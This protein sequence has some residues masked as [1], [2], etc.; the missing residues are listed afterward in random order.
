MNQGRYEFCAGNGKGTKV[1]ANQD[2]AIEKKLIAETS[3]TENEDQKHRPYTDNAV[4]K[5]RREAEIENF[6]QACTYLNLL[7]RC[8]IQNYGHTQQDYGV[9]PLLISSHFFT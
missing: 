6:F 2:V 1:G 7:P 9:T 3:S 4:S 5:F 8:S